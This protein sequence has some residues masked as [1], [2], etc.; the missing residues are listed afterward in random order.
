ITTLENWVN[1]TNKII[2][3]HNNFIVNFDNEQTDARDK[4]K[5]HQ[6]ATFLVDE[7]YLTKQKN[8]NFA[9]RCIDRYETYVEGL[10]EQNKLLESQLKSIVAGKKELNDFIQRFLNRDDILID[11]VEDDKFVLKRGDKIAKN[12]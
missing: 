5:K 2:V 6:V 7:S 3:A 12:F 8:K 9:E 10:E 1:A 4:L 11:V